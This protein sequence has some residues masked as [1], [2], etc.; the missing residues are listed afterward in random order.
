MPNGI[1]RN[2]GGESGNARCTS[3]CAMRGIR[4]V[5]ERSPRAQQEDAIAREHA[6]RLAQPRSRV[7]EEHHAELAH[8]DVE[9][10]VVEG[11]RHGVGLANL[12][13]RI[14]ADLPAATSS[15]PGWRSVTTSEAAGPS[16]AR[17]WRD[18]MP[19]PAAVSRTRV[20]VAGEPIGQIAG[21]G[22]EEHRPQLAV[23]HRRDGTGERG[24][25][26]GHGTRSLQLGDARTKR[27]I[28]GARPCCRAT[29]GRRR[30]IR[31]ARGWCVPRRRQGRHEVGVEAPFRLRDDGS[32]VDG[33]QQR[34]VV[35]RI[36]EAER[37]G[38]WRARA[39]DDADRRPLVGGAGEMGRSA[40]RESRAPRR[41]APPHRGHPG[42]LHPTGRRTAP[43]N[44]RCLARAATASVNPV[45]SAT[46]A[47]VMPE[48]PR[49]S[50]PAAAATGSS[51][52]LRAP[53]GVPSTSTRPSSATRAAPSGT[54]DQVSGN[55]I[56]PP[57]ST[58]S[59][60]GASARRAARARISASVLLL[61]G[62][63]GTAPR[64][65]A[66]A[67]LAARRRPNRCG[68]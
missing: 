29:P 46:S 41:H 63:I 3:S 65:A 60:A 40:H 12:D 51:L 5:L 62:T 38:A 4:V 61:H 66:L 22:L 45:R 37:P 34:Q 32:I 49:T 2:G 27:P 36:A 21:V 10:L 42:L 24:G 26:I 52:D 43:R 55:Q 47:S 48:N 30:S 23:V 53:A 20:A 1:A 57:F 33:S 31:R 64:R 6:S 14:L 39:A 19:V 35:R 8:D 7:R 18:T 13:P 11:Q 15:M 54:A 28:T 16:L 44:W 68:D 17:R 50:T 58:M 59:G 25:R 56:A 9:L 67:A